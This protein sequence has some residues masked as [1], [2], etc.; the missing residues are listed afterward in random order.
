MSIRD[1]FQKYEQILPIPNLTVVHL[2]V[3]Y[4]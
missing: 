3:A 4:I 1:Y 2:N